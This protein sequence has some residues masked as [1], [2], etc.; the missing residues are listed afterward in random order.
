[1]RPPPDQ[2]IKRSL[3]AGDLRKLVTSTVDASMPVP[4]G[5]LGFSLSTMLELPIGA[6]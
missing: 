3:S 6:V 5:S 4:V 1:V 2:S